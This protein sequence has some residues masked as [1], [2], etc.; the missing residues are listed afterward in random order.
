MD[1]CVFYWSTP[2]NLSP[3]LRH[4]PLCS[5]TAEALQAA[6][7]ALQL[8]G[9]IPLAVVQVLGLPKQQKNKPKNILESIMWPDPGVLFSLILLMQSVPSWWIWGLLK[10]Q[11][12]CYLS[13]RWDREVIQMHNLAIFVDFM[14]NKIRIS[15]FKKQRKW[16]VTLC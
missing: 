9:H 13:L 2:F 12:Q 7:S 16:L 3:Q 14:H 5:W 8:A 15:E 11:K 1:F 6:F 10:K 4:F